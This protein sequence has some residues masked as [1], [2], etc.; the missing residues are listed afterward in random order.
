MGQA[1]V[2][3][4]HAL[5]APVPDAGRP[6]EDNPRITDCPLAAGAVGG[7]P[8]YGQ[9]ARHDDPRLEVARGRL[10]KGAP[11]EAELANELARDQVGRHHSGFVAP[12][13]RI[14]EPAVR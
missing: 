5:N 13:L 14:G 6:Q 9:V 1:A 11:K 12:K 2:D 3:A 8:R 4:G 10:A 7:E